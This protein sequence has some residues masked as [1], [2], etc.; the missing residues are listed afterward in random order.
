M[1]LDLLLVE[2]FFNPGLSLLA[3]G[4]F[5]GIIYQGKESLKAINSSDP[6]SNNKKPSPNPSTINAIISKQRERVVLVLFGS[7]SIKW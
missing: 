3:P 4:G 2:S 1:D 5:M 6:T 7:I